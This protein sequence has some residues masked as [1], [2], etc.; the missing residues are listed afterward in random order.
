LR[1]RE[2]LSHEQ[3]PDSLLW[4]PTPIRQ[5]DARWTAIATF[6]N[7]RHFRCSR[8]FLEKQY[9]QRPGNYYAGYSVYPV[10]I[11]LYIWVPAVQKLF[12]LKKRG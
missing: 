8:Q 11:L 7:L 2:E 3:A 5:Q 10:G 12:L 1:L 9:L 4:R 6:D